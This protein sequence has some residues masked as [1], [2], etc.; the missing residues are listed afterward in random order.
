MHK[1]SH[2]HADTHHTSSLI[3]SKKL[4][5]RKLRSGS[6]HPCAIEGS[7]CDPAIY[8]DTGTQHDSKGAMY[9]LCPLSQHKSCSKAAHCLD[10]NR[11][12]RDEGGNNRRLADDSGGSAN[13]NISDAST[14]LITTLTDLRLRTL[15]PLMN[16]QDWMNVRLVQVCFQ[17]TFVSHART[18][19]ALSRIGQQ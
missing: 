19:T 4:L 5:R 16:Q 2:H 17:S 9:L 6:T 18:T 1:V 13:R 15:R 8:S 3:S 12:D 7:I 10:D 14:T 11:V